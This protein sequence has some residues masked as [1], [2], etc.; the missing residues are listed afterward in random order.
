MHRAG[1]TE[2]SWKTAGLKQDTGVYDDRSPRLRSQINAMEKYS[3][4]I[5]FSGYGKSVHGH[6]M[7][8]SADNQSAPSAHFAQGLSNYTYFSSAAWQPKHLAGHF[9]AREL[10][11]VR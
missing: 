2:Y 5:L 6:I 4:H 10:F 11:P 7:D 3:A 9:G 8:G 1:A